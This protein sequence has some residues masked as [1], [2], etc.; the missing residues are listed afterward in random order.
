MYRVSL[1]KI[2]ANKKEKNKPRRPSRRNWL[3]HKKCNGITYEKPRCS[4]V[5][6]ARITFDD[7]SRMERA[8]ERSYLNLCY[9]QCL[10]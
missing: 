1:V 10:L 9:Q 3:A 5:T 8:T 4:G 7:M 2:R 6:A